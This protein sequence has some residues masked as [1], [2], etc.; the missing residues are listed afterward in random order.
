[1]ERA[2]A[3]EWAWTE[4]IDPA[5]YAPRIQQVALFR[6]NRRYPG[7]VF[8]TLDLAGWS[9]ASSEEFEGSSHGCIT[10]ERYTRSS[11]MTG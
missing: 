4:Q 3:G 11:T 5:P 1:M 9:L 2:Q 7:D 10:L 8:F 6:W